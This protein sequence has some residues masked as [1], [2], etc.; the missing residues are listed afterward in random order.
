MMRFHTALHLLCAVVKAPVTGGR[1][2]DDKAHLDFDIEMEKLGNPAQYTPDPDTLWQRIR[3]PSRNA[4]V[5][6]RMRALATSSRTR[7]A[8]QDDSVTELDN[9]R[10][11]HIPSVRARCTGARFPFSCAPLPLLPAAKR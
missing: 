5:M 8:S 1:V 3:A 11:R 2:G 10:M 9:N 4:Q 6:G 7:N